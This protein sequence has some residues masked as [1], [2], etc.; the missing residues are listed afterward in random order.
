MVSGSVMQIDAFGNIIW[1]NKKGEVHRS[2]GPAVES[3]NG[4]KYWYKNGVYHRAKGPAI[5]YA[6][7]DKYWYKNGV[8]HRANGPAKELMCGNKFWYQNGKLHRED[9]PAVEFNNGHKE[10]FRNGKLHR[11]DGPAHINKI[12]GIKSWYIDGNYFL[13]KEEFFNSLSDREKILALFS[14]DFLYG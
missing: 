3:P 9:G 10:W 13:N 8:Y 4:D 12:S 1:K 7:G 5:E 11:L 6:N 2:N 14:E